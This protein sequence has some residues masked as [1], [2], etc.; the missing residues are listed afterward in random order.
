MPVATFSVV[1]LAKIGSTQ[2]NSAGGEP[3]TQTAP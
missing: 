2:S 3:P 1:V